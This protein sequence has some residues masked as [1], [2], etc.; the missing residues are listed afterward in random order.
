MKSRFFLQLADDILLSLRIFTEI[1]TWNR[2]A[3]LEGIKLGL[4]RV[5]DGA[6][7]TQEVGNKVEKESVPFTADEFFN[8]IP[9]P[10]IYKTV[11][12]LISDDKI[13]FSFLSFFCK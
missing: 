12:G 13:A 11:R 8:P 4:Q 1:S 7:A 3:E 10:S 5:N 9:P 2:P 6:T